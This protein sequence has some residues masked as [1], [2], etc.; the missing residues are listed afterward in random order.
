MS[1]PQV[2]EFHDRLRRVE[3]IHR[4]G[5]GFEAAGTLS[6]PYYVQRQRRSW[7]RPALLVVAGVFVLKS[8]LLAQIGPVD[9][10][11]RVEALQGGT[12][13]E[14]AGA[15]VLQMDPATVWLSERMIE[16]FTPPV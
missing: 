11:G 15:W 9:Y 2:Q 16:I 5:G 10:Q 13:L 4:R 7:L 6:R 8:A 14:E 3:R 1:D 12:Q